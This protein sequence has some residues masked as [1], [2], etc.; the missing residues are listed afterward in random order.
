M[1]ISISK[2]SVIGPSHSEL[3]VPNQ[4]AVASRQS[5]GRWA[6]AVADGMGSR[7]LS[8]I[9]SKLATHLAVRCCLEKSEDISDK[10]LIT[11]IYTK[12]L[13]GLKDKNIAPNDAVTTLM[14]AWGN[15]KGEY[16]FIQLGDGVIC[17]S[18]INHSVSE[19]DLF[20]NDTTGLGLSKKFSDWRIGRGR[21]N[22]AIGGLIL[23]TDGISEDI[24]DHLGFCGTLVRRA[25]TCSPRAVKKN[26]KGLLHNWPTPHHTDD[27]TIAMVLINE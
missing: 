5:N 22:L 1:K 25:Q 10:E 15:S 2:M 14:V 12:W 16:R 13:D 23:M 26:L 9:G 21:L 19:D 27:K 3:R 6:V 11:D 4:D 24:E 17:N 8:H 7:D 20:S 18:T